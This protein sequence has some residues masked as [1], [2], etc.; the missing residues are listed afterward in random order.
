LG[1]VFKEQEL[2]FYGMVGEFS[3]LKWS[4]MQRSVIIPIA[5]IANEESKLIL[6]SYG[7]SSEGNSFS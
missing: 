1:K 5:V 7:K 3:E 2:L 4:G 6:A